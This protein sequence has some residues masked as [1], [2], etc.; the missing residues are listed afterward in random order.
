MDNGTVPQEP[1]QCSISRQ[2]FVAILYRIAVIVAHKVIWIPFA[3]ISNIYRGAFITHLFK[4]TESGT[5]VH[6]LF[7]QMV[8]RKNL[9]CRRYIRDRSRN[10]PQK[11]FRFIHVIL[12]NHAQ[13][14]LRDGSDYIKCPIGFSATCI[15]IA[16]QVSRKSIRRST[17][18][19]NVHFNHGIF[20]HR[21]VTALDIANQAS[22]HHGPSCRRN[23]QARIFDFNIRKSN[24]I[25]FINQDRSDITY[26]C[27]LLVFFKLHIR[28]F[29]FQFFDGR[30]IVP[31][32]KGCLRIITCY[33]AKVF[34][35]VVISVNVHR[36]GHRG[37]R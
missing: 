37:K 33:I 6:I 23:A 14:T 20:H 10:I 9:A 19:I 22:R 21:S 34:D 17:N 25:G 13:I 30:N 16:E 24:I 3:P 8:I 12:R 35:E 27:R 18:N 7:T 28:I 32:D 11:D 15:D 31:I 5:H 36:I 29:H 4:G 1:I 2:G 26:G